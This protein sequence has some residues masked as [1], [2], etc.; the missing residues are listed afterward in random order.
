MQ[1]RF[2]PYLL[3]VTLLFTTHMYAQP[4][5]LDA[6][7]VKWFAQSKNASESMPCGGGDIGLNVWV[8]N[9]ELLL[10]VGRSGS[11]D[12][13]NTLLKSGRIRIRLSP[14]SFDENFVQELDLK[15]GSV[16]IRSGKGKRQTEIRVW[17]DVFQPVIHVETRSAQALNIEAVFES[18][19]YRPD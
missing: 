12:E 17:V 8:E 1:H 10:Y 11:F 9:N 15:T 5:E 3:A 13:H 6:C 7:N 14:H 19:R 2:R 16:I 4:P 18:W